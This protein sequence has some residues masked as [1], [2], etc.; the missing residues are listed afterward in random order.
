MFTPDRFGAM[1]N[2][3][4]LDVMMDTGYWAYSFVLFALIL[5]LNAIVNRSVQPLQYLI[6]TIVTL[7]VLLVIGTIF[8]S[9]VADQTL[10]RGLFKLFPFMWMFMAETALMRSLSERIRTWELGG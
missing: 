8:A 6:W 4:V 7:L 2:D 1:F 3:L 9:A 5:I 10:R